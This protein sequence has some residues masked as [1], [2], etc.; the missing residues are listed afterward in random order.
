MAAV[1][2]DEFRPETAPDA[3]DVT[4]ARVLLNSLEPA[5]EDWLVRMV[6]L[7]IPARSVG[8]LVSVTMGPSVAVMEEAPAVADW[9]A[10]LMT[11][12]MSLMMEVATWELASWP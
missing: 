10:L 9:T 4:L 6:L 3:L 12:S 8:W 7:L 1:L 11:D 5:A 2:T